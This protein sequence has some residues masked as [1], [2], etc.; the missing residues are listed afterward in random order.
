MPAKPILHYCPSVTG[1]SAYAVDLA[2]SHHSRVT[3]WDLDAYR[4]REGAKGL[5]CTA[6]RYVSFPTKAIYMT[7]EITVC[8][9]LY[10]TSSAFQ[11][12]F[13]KDDASG[14]RSWSWDY[15][16]GL[17]R[18]IG[19]DKSGSYGY[20]S[21]AATLNKWTFLAGTFS[22]N[23]AI[24]YKDGSFKS[25]GYSSYGG[26]LIY[27]SNPIGVGRYANYGLNISDGVIDDCRVY[28]QALPAN[29][30]AALFARGPGYIDYD[31][32]D[33]CEDESMLELPV[34]PEAPP[35]WFAQ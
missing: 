35:L 24:L 14:N 9:W 31:L 25:I 5:N 32:H 20:A 8:C 23:A 10:L 4:C 27:N 6:T 29:D 26:G 33:D 18:W 28:K 19:F 17:W 16:G 34:A 15:Y 3:G 7:D 2:A 22:H 13:T 11:G 12:F 21:T 1:A 30:I